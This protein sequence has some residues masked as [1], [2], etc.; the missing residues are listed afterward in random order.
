MTELKEFRNIKDSIWQ[1]W[2]I[3]NQTIKKLDHEI[4]KLEK[5]KE[6]ALKAHTIKNNELIE[7]SNESKKISLY[8]SECHT[9]KNHIKNMTGFM[10][11]ITKH[12]DTL[13]KKSGNSSAS[14][15]N[16]TS[17]DDILS[18]DE[19]EVKINKVEKERSDISDQL[20]A[21]DRSLDEGMKQSKRLQD[22]LASSR[23]ALQVHNTNI[24][25]QEN[26]D[27]TLKQQN[28][29]DKQLAKEISE[30]DTEAK[31]LRK[32]E[33]KHQGTLDA[34][35]EEHED[36]I[37]AV[38]Q[39]D[40]DCQ[41]SLVAYKESHKRLEKNASS[42]S[43]ENLNKCDQDIIKVEN[44]KKEIEM[45][46]LAQTPIIKDLERLC[47][48]SSNQIKMINENIQ[49]RQL[50]QELNNLNEDK[51]VRETEYASFDPKTNQKR[52]I[53]LEKLI[54][55]LNNEMSKSTG[56]KDELKRQLSGTTRE[57][58]GKKRSGKRINLVWFLCVISNIF[59]SFFFS[60]FFFS[61]FLFLLL[62]CLSR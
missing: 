38:K 28:E 1:P 44:E 14:L 48:D 17:V 56:S 55:A 36:S 4:K 53:E 20:V 41:T 49:W 25:D 50:Q 40:I 5:S 23:N 54:K 34:K 47:N 37:K 45:Y 18:M 51:D 21:L 10:K 43:I 57:L 22:N 58:K 35:S 61:F 46:V 7:K 11:Q 2:N 6:E 3:E 24:K 8:R 15:A 19:C 27:E 32:I 13:P 42:K 29:R 12:R 39:R 52:L 33:I 59:N 60:S 9:L 26:L 16:G 62:P 31:E 30:G